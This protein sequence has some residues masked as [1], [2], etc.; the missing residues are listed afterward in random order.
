[1]KKGYTFEIT[2]H[3]L[4]FHENASI[5]GLSS[6]DNHLL[7][8]GSDCTVRC[9]HIVLKQK[10]N[11]NILCYPDNSSVSFVYCCTLT[12]PNSVN[13]IRS[14][15]RYVAAGTTMGEIYI[16]KEKGCTFEECAIRG[17]D[18]DSC[19]EIVFVRREVA[20]FAF[21][22]GRLM[23][24]EI[25]EN[26]EQGDKKD[27]E[28]AVSENLVR[29]GTDEEKLDKDTQN[30]HSSDVGTQN[31]SQVV[32]N[33][34][35]TVEKKKIKPLRVAKLL[36]YK[37]LNVIKPHSLSIQ[38]LA[39]NAKYNILSTF[40]KDKTM[41]IFYITNKM[42]LLGK[43]SNAFADEQEMI[44][45]RRYK[46][47]HNN[48]FL[49][50]GGCIGN[51]LHILHFPF[52]G[53]C[54]LGKIGPFEAHVSVI[55][56]YGGKE[57]SEL[58]EKRALESK[59]A[60]QVRERW[61]KIIIDSC[62]E[63]GEADLEHSNLD[64]IKEEMCT[65]ISNISAGL[66]FGSV[67]EEENVFNGLPAKELFCDKL[68]SNDSVFSKGKFKSLSRNVKE[69]GHA[70][71]CDKINDK[72]LKYELNVEKSG[73]CNKNCDKAQQLD[74]EVTNNTTIDEKKDGK[75]INDSFNMDDYSFTISNTD[76]LVFF[77][78]K[79][80]LYC[81]N[82]TGIVCKMENVCYKGITDIMVHNNVVFISSV[83]G[84]LSSVRF[85]D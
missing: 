69:G 67:F 78:V 17:G 13:I 51:Y 45:F 57:C 50:V 31:N 15:G 85:L 29:N 77:A 62:T 53:T 43:L 58:P 36:S 52:C 63:A 25:I 47:S 23:M 60:K 35:K 75:D 11:K 54:V 2:K 24:Y 55:Y 4:H 32:E 80:H 41:K 42:T 49:Y 66:G 72:S 21:E 61:K 27:D 76:N 39:Y 79:N 84:L 34:S 3:T 59:N 7:T 74:S 18:G 33:N 44:L 38:G 5:Y 46:F 26:G 6:T 20:V 73:S 16:F 12:L 48:E 70:L 56:E 22:S 68:Q 64:P 19:N 10:K 82:R 71:N 30:Y 81:M 28:K 14:H 83:D 8:A 65:L 40:S 9:W 1:M 37:L